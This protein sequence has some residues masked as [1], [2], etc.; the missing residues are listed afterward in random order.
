MC[1]SCMGSGKV[2]C[3]GCGGRGSIS[4]LTPNGEIDITSCIVCGGSRRSRCDFCG[5]SGTI[6]PPDPPPI[7]KPFVPGSPSADPLE[8][9]W[10]GPQGTWYFLTRTG[11]TYQLR[12]GGPLGESQSGTA[13][14][15]GDRV[16]MSVR[17]AF[18]GD[19]SVEARLTGNSL[20]G[21]VKV[22]GFA[23]PFHFNRG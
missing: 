3:I 7:P 15:D 22:M 6:G 14:R 13:Q 18:V 23:T 19:F 12:G 5:G 20:V 17:D 11:T 4:R 16:T 21:V 8:G 1:G 10:N 9:R 2:S